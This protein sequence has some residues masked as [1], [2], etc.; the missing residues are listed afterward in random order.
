VS[1]RTLSVGQKVI[2]WEKMFTNPTFNRGLISKI[3]LELKKELKKFDSRETDNPII[4]G[5]QS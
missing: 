1:Q 2:D 5:V 3:A 4:N